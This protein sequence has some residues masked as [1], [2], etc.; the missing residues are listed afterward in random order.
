MEN[1]LAR[2]KLAVA[3]LLLLIIGG[4]LFLRLWDIGKYGFW[5]DELY[6]VIP[7][8]SIIENGKPY[9][10][11]LGEY[12]RAAPFTYI[13][14]TLFKW[15]G[16]NEIVA[17]MPSLI[18]NISLIVPAFFIISRFINKTGAF[19][20]VFVM[21]FSPFMIEQSRECRM[22]ALFQ[23]LYFLMSYFF[24]IG[25]E[26]NNKKIMLFKKLESNF[27]IS[28]VYLSICIFLFFVSNNIHKLTYN[29]AFV[30]LFY[31]LTML[32]YT[33]HKEG[34][35]LG[36]RSKYF[37][38]LTIMIGS[39]LFVYI[40][41]KDL[42]I[43]MWAIATGLPPWWPASKQPSLNYYRY[44]LSDNYPALFFIYP[45]SS[46]FMIKHLG[47]K[48]L[49]IFSSFAVLFIIHTFLFSRQLDRYIFY[50]FPF[51]VLGSVYLFSLMLPSLPGIVKGELKTSSKILK[52]IAIFSALVA[53]NIFCYPWLGNSKNVHKTSIGVDFKH[54]PEHIKNE[55][56]KAKVITT[57]PMHYMYY[58]NETPDW[59]IRVPGRKYEQVAD[60]TCNPG[61]IMDLEMLRFIFRNT[62]ATLYIVTTE[63]R[64]NMDVFVS[65][66]MRTFL[67]EN[68]DPVDLGTFQN[69]IVLRKK[70]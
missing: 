4:G 22:Y 53:F 31:S 20:F 8:Q 60:K 24:F 36:I 11:I 40:F 66:S 17:R 58:F 3:F 10:P 30:V 38:V 51:F 14:A 41:K 26:N 21:S 25:F 5:W 44:F 18:F 28:L 49:F 23:L 55:I 32:A 47:K 16:A 54:F 62:K 29:F 1:F 63:K 7:A 57:H 2:N 13:I 27:G 68:T 19:L 59:C 9:I 34:I 67:L 12:T 39:I 35:L 52:G 65:K 46:L 61:A 69:V 70:P 42:L 56:K 43:A 6:H 45:L 50:F 15:F 64:F 37:L 33:I 48:G